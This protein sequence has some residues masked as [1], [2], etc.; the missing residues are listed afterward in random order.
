[1]PRAQA[2]VLP[3]DHRLPRVDPQRTASR[4]VFIPVD[5]LLT[6]GFVARH[7]MFPD[8]GA[9]LRASAFV[10]EQVVFLERTS[11]D[12]WEKFIRRVSSFSTW[13]A[14]LKDARGEW[15]MRRMGVC[16]DAYP[17]YSEA[18]ATL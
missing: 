2:N 12:D 6:P 7:T 3:L 5:E 1:M 14:M 4:A 9:L 13:N 15:I 18:P 17:S 16:I 10:P 11:D 8:F